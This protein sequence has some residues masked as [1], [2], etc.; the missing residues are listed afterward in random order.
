M[1]TEFFP[2]TELVPCYRERKQDRCSEC[3]LDQ[4]VRRMP[5]DYDANIEALVHEVLDPARCILGLPIRINSGFRCLIHNTAVGGAKNSQHTLGQA[6][7]LSVGSPEANLRLARILA[8][9]IY[10]QMILYVNSV[11]SLAP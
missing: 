8:A 3:R 4:A 6:A 1:K 11:D 7:D 2:Q 10:D 5:N 9:G